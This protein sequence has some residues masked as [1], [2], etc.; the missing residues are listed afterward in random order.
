VERERVR[1]TERGREAS[2]CFWLWIEAL[3]LIAKLRSWLEEAAK[4][5]VKKKAESL[6]AMI[7]AVSL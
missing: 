3:L 7:H 6:L 1:E 2:F 5:G 4:E